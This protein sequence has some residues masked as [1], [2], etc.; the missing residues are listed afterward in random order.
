MGAKFSFLHVDITSDVP[1]CKFTLKNGS[2][3]SYLCF[4]LLCD[5]HK[6]KGPL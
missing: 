3:K 5:G 2:L 4:R 6:S 1:K